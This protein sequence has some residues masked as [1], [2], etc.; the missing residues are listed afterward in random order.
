MRMS[1]RGILKAARVLPLLAGSSAL[2][3]FSLRAWGQTAATASS[4]VEVPI[5]RWN[6]PE[7]SKASGCFTARA[8]A[9]RR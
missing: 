4:T 2:S 7:L 9:D 3:A 6:W 5:G 1:R 8:V